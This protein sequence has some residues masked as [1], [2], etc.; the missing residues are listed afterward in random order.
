MYDSANDAIIRPFGTSSSPEF[1]LRL[2]SK[3]VNETIDYDVADYL[4]RI[5]DEKQ[6]TSKQHPPI[7]R[8][9]QL[10]GQAADF[11]ATYPALGLNPFC[12]KPLLSPGA[13]THSSKNPARIEVQK[14]TT[15]GT[16]GRGH[17]IVGTLISAMNYAGT[18]R[19]QLAPQD[20]RNQVLARCPKRGLVDEDYAKLKSVFTTAFPDAEY[21][22][23]VDSYEAVR[24][25]TH[26]G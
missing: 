16:S 17:F 9:L 20:V 26:R 14:V 3:L 18:Q 22:E 13:V 25:S 2:K 6:A 23:N 24:R 12:V 4:L 7:A 11:L 8:C 15:K 5:A 10:A 1:D 19:F 21:F